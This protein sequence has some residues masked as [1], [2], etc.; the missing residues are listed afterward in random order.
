MKKASAIC[1]ICLLMI[2]AVG[3]SVYSSKNPATARISQIRVR[4]FSGADKSDIEYVEGYRDSG[5][6]FYESGTVL[7]NNVNDYILVTYICK[8]KSNC[9]SML[10]FIYSMV[11]RVPEND[12]AYISAHKQDHVSQAFSFRT[13][14]T[15]SYVIFDR[16]G[17]TDEEVNDK[18]KAVELDV[19]YKR[20]GEAGITKVKGIDSFESEKIQWR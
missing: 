18:I 10:D 17:L 13:A 16:K 15:Y 2:L 4:A 8:V 3:Y 9:P 11:H 5:Q 1:A 19:I 14:T 20:K 7:N 12:S 6:I